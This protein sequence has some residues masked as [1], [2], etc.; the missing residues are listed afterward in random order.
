MLPVLKMVA[1][2][3]STTQSTAVPTGCFY[4]AVIEAVLLKLDD[5][6]ENE[7][8]KTKEI[9]KALKKEIIKRYDETT[10]FALMVV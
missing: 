2:S 6:T 5:F 9:A 1:S 10:C 4:L 3:G 7:H 8:A